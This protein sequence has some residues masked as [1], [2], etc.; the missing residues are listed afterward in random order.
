MHDQQ[1]HREPIQARDHVL[2]PAEV[3]LVAGEL[4]V[5]DRVGHHDYVAAA[6]LLAALVQKTTGVS[7]AVAHNGWPASPQAFDS[8]RTLVFYGGGGRKHALVAS[9]AR[10]RKMQELVTDGVGLVMI[11]QAV[12]Y[13]PNLADQV[14]PWLGGVHISGKSGRGHWPTEH[15]DFPEHP[16]TR[17]VQPWVST[18]GWMNE[19]RFAAGMTGITPLLWS[20]REHRGSSRGGDAAIVS[21][22]YERPS[23]GRAFCF[24]GLDAHATWS[25][26]GVRQLVVNGILWSAGREIPEGGAPCD[27]D[28]A[29]LQAYLTPRGT[30]SAL[31]LKAVRRVV[32]RLTSP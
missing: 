3:L 2:Q 5:P 6:A 11:H 9:E 13:P 18:D 24:T 31:L 4:T 7:A 25:I 16:V 28:E 12:R 17:G 1:T 27:I 32:S 30:R 15:R 10:R 14:I 26:A 8:I 22:A 23:G 29:T 20:S 21:W 19:I